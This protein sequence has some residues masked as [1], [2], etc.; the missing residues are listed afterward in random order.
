[1]S[2]CA[3]LLQ[4]V[5][6]CS[7]MCDS[8]LILLSVDLCAL[9]GVVGCCRRWASRCLLQAGCSSSVGSSLS[10][11]GVEENSRDLAFFAAD[12]TVIWQISESTKYRG[13]GDALSSTYSQT[14]N[15]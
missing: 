10:V 7:C 13:I 12:Q 8:M 6:S 15:R 9:V 4:S 1:M 14:V 3:R 2:V 5:F 11:G